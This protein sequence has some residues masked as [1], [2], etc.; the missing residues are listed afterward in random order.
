MA[1]AKTESFSAELQEMAAFATALSHPARIAILMHLQ[2]HPDSPCKE[3]IGVTGLS[4]PSCSR[5]L[6]ELREAGLVTAHPL[7]NHVRYALNKERIAT[8]CEAFHCSLNPESV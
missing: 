6:H 1:F 5:H 3:L 4:Q 7:R 2:N 8:F